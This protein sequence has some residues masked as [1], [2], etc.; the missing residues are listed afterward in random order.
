MVP[1]RYTK[2]ATIAFFLLK[3]CLV[4]SQPVVHEQTQ[5]QGTN[6]APRCCSFVLCTSG[7]LNL[8]PSIM[9]VQIVDAR[10]SHGAGLEI[11]GRSMTKTERKGI[12]K[13]QENQ[14][15]ILWE[16]AHGTF[17]VIA[18]QDTTISCRSLIRSRLQF[19]D[20]ASQRYRKV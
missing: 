16:R 9:N 4:K 18:T 17:R 13:T 15:S 10:R 12:F 1:I 3:R 14:M 8:T 7:T 6:Q 19:I 5:L 20:L 2:E 11:G